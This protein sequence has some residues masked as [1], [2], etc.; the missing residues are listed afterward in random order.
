M[1]ISVKIVCM[2][3]VPHLGTICKLPVCSH[4]KIATVFPSFFDVG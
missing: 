4:F 2:P 1:T 3:C